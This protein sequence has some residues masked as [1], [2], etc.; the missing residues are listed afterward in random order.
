MDGASR[1]LLA[2]TL[3]QHAGPSKRS[4]D[5]CQFNKLEL[6]DEQIWYQ[7]VKDNIDAEVSA[8]LP[9]TDRL[10]DLSL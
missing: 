8:E 6:L 1:M 4:D 9:P 2:P 10:Q 7:Q 3:R 5:A